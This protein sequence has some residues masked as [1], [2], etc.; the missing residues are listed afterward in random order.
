MFSIECPW[1]TAPAVV[2]LTDASGFECAACAI[3]VEIA[4]DPVTEP[5][6]LA[7]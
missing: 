6:A 4:P 1:C 3:E 7:A 2:H 5:V